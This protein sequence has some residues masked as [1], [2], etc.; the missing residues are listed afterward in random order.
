MERDFELIRRILKDIEKTSAGEIIENLDYPNAYPTSIVYEH[1]KLLV[2]EGFVE[3]EALQNNNH[4]IVVIRIYRLTWKGHDFVK[5][6]QDESLWEKAKSSVLK[7]TMSFTFDFLLA[8]IKE[9]A[10]EKLGIP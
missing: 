2:D 10:K 6:T 9:E 1:V 4:E 5:V 8:W 7:P 3:G